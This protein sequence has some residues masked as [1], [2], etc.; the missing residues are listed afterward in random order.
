MGE[1]KNFEQQIYQT[2]KEILKVRP[3]YTVKQEPE[4]ISGSFLT[5]Q[6]C[7]KRIRNSTQIY[8]I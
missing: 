8:S 1:K 5:H 6:H 4:S 2:A 3:K 7:H